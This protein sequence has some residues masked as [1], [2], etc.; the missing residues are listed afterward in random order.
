MPRQQPWRTIYR[1]LGKG[2]DYAFVT[3]SATVEWNGD[4]RTVDGTIGWNKDV[5]M[6]DWLTPPQQVRRWLRKQ[7]DRVVAD[8]RA[9]KVAAYEYVHREE[10]AR[11]RRQADLDAATEEAYYEALE[12]MER[13]EVDDDD[14]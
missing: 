9:V 6:Y 4:E 14:D 11:A 8:V 7:R 12:R 13:A 3:G 10:L 5:V 1:L 2:E